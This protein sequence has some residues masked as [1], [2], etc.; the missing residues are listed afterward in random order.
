MT[1]SITQIAGFSGL[2]DLP[3]WQLSYHGA[4][5]IV[6]SYGAHVLHY[7]PAGQAP[8]LTAQVA[9]PILWLSPLA[10]WQQQQPIRGGVP[11]CWPWFGKYPAHLFP[12]NTAQPNHGLVRCRFWQL[13][14]QHCD[15]QQVWIKFTITVDDIPWST[16]PVTLSYRIRLTNCLELTLECQQSLPQ[17][18]ALHSY[19]TVSDS[20]ATQACPLPAQWY[21]KVTDQQEQG[22]S[23][24]LT[25]LGEIDR[26]YPNTAAQLQ[27]QC[28]QEQ[29]KIDQ[30][31]HDASILWNP[32]AAK[33]QSATDIPDDGWQD[34][35]CVETASL[36]WQQAPL[37]LIQIIRP[38][39]P[40]T[41]NDA[42]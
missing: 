3:C 22:D 38:T 24:F 31:G 9:Q 13:Q 34:F 4:V 11:V 39:Q 28:R 6:S 15:E 37:R 30:L 14:D 8:T 20:T 18:G 41:S 2:T 19:F 7:Q 33:S 25:F 1:T 29:L 16:Q 35:V 36:H 5:V 27:L 12:S 23:G 32:A 17:Q 42:V 26:V 10:Q 40:T 21:N